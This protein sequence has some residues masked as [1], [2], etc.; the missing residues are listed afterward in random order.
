[1]IDVLC[2][3]LVC[4]QYKS[5]PVIGYH[6]FALLFWDFNGLVYA[7]II[8]DT[9]RFACRA[10]FLA[11]IGNFYQ[12]MHHIKT[13]VTDPGSANITSDLVVAGYRLQVIYFRSGQDDTVMVPIPLNYFAPIVGTCDLEIG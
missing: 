7:V 1:M 5:G 3:V 2:G 8:T 4:V 6:A 10:N 12:H 9:D 13:T 11:I